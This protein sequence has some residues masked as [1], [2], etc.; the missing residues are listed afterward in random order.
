MCLPD[1]QT[2][3]AV[4]DYNAGNVQSVLFALDKFEVDPVLTRDPEIILSS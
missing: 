1:E 4:I 2:K 3:I